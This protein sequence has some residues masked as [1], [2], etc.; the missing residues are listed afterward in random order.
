[1]NLNTIQTPTT[2]VYQY[3]LPPNTTLNY[4]LPVIKI[5]SIEL[6]DS[7]KLEIIKRQPQNI[8]QSYG[9]N[10]CSVPDSVWKETYG[11]KEGKIFLESVILGSVI[12]ETTIPEQ[13]SFPDDLE[14]KK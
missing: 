8:I 10:Y 4:T 5:V 7:G 11:V 1:M 3:N 14:N 9:N 12:P 13:I 2:G 6:K